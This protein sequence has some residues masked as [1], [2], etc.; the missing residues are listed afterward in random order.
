MTRLPDRRRAV[1]LVQQAQRAGARLSQ[2]CALLGLSVRTYPRWTATGT[3]VADRRPEAVR[4]EPHNK[5]SAAEREAIVT[6]CNEA[7]Y[8]SRPPGFIV[9]D[10]ADQGRY[11]ASES[12]FYRVLREHG[13]VQHRGRQKAPRPKRPPTTH[14]ATAPNELWSWD[15]SWL[16]GPAR[17]SGYYLYLILDVF[18]RKIVGHEVYEAE[19][20]ELAAQLIEKAH[21]REHLAGKAK[22]LVLHSDNGSPMKAATFL[23]KLYELGIAPSHSRPRVSNDNAFS[24]ALFRTVKFRPGYPAAGFADLTAAR[25]WMQ[26]F[27]RWYNTEHRHSA[28]RYVTPEQRHTGQATVILTNRM[29]VYKRAKQH[30]HRPLKNPSGAGVAPSVKADGDVIPR[31]LASG[32]LVFA[33]LLE[34]VLTVLKL[35]KALQPLDTARDALRTASYR[36][37]L[38]EVSWLES[39]RHDHSG[40]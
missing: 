9:A 28:L 34:A 5:L 35:R 18:S 27:V 19:T 14:T 36:A 23:E 12:T 20:G 7:G 40:G 24:E 32:L 29:V 13:Q 39:S 15:V 17:G 6:L 4:P 38:S 2:A 30:R 37:E 16:P 11:L 26:A 33:Q 3:V 21:W 22:P 8:R 25:E 10:Q 1:E 31:C